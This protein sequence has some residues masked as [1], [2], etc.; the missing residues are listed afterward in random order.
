MLLRQ[1]VRHGQDESVGPG[2]VQLLVL[3][4]ETGGLWS[5][6]VTALGVQGIDQVI[7]LVGNGL[8]LGLDAGPSEQG[9]W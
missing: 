1:R 9:H 8:D 4:G 5:A 3:S 2:R 6:A 7:E